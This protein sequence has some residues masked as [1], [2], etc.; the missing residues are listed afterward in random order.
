VGEIDRTLGV[1]NIAIDKQWAIGGRLGILSTPSTLLYA[2]AGYTH[3]DF[4][5]SQLGFNVIDEA[6]DGIFVGLGYEQTISRNLSLKLDYRF[7]DYEDL[8][9]GNGAN[10]GNEVHSVRL[11]VNWKFGRD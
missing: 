7:S 3:A 9:L 10:V 8:V 2:S 4:E 1:L 11:G 6:V 5:A